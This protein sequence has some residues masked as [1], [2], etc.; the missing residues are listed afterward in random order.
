MM[1]ADRVTV[2]LEVGRYYLVPVV[3]AK[4]HYIE[5]DW[6]VMGPLHA[7]VE[8]FNFQAEHYHVDGRFFTKEQIEIAE[9]DWR[10]LAADVQAVPLHAYPG[11]PALPKPAL[12]KRRCRFPQLPYEHGDKKPIQDLR[13][14]YA[15]AQCPRGKSGWICP[16]RKVSLGSVASID[17][18]ITCPLHGLRFDAATAS[19]GEIPGAA[20]IRGVWSFD[21]ALLDAMVS[22]PE[23]RR[24]VGFPEDLSPL[25]GK[26]LACFC[27]IG[28]PCHA[29][30]LLDV[31]NAIAPAHRG[32]AAQ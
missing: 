17:G 25:A 11:D 32:D 20:K 30:V 7:D 4:W 8:F 5:S 15:G 1:R 2:P 19:R 10:P 12:A 27:E 14:H 9:S 22:D 18:V 24:S 16:H 6:P 26:N 29:D 28:Q 31:A 23:I 21:I 13:K 3:R